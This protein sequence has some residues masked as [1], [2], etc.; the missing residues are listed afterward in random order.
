MPF[1]PTQDFFDDRGLRGGPTVLKRMRTKVHEMQ[2]PKRSISNLETM[3]PEADTRAAFVQ[4]GIA[5][6]ARVHI[7]VANSG[8]AGVHTP[9]RQLDHLAG[10][11]RLS[12]FKSD[13]SEANH[14]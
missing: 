10:A 7:E 9:A 3:L 12:A 4:S 11:S 2:T 5:L 8:A 6:H 13:Q 1:D 14:G